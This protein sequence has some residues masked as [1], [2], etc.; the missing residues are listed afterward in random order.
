[1]TKQAAIS[2]RKASG[3]ANAWIVA[4]DGDLRGITVWRAGGE[5]ERW[6][7]PED[8]ADHQTGAEERE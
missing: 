4:V 1:M 7:G 6:V 5:A 3:G 2:E 8:A